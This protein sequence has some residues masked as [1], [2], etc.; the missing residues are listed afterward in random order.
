MTEVFT[1][2]FVPTGTRSIEEMSSPRRNIIPLTNCEFT[3]DTI[4]KVLHDINK[5]PGIIFI[6]FTPIQKRGYRSLTVSCRPFR[7]TSIVSQV[8]EIIIRNKV[9]SVLEK[10][11][12]IKNSKPSSRN[13]C[14]CLTNFL[15]FYSEVYNIYDGK[16]VLHVIYLDFHTAFDKVPYTRLLLKLK[17]HVIS[18]KIYT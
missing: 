14:S 1:D 6:S 17:A 12:L 4:I 5:T 11:Q 10:N 3:E 8:M 2:Y 13:K 15:G 9:I 18:G 7:L 16:I